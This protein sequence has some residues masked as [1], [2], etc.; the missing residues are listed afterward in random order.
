[1]RRI[2]LFLGVFSVGLVLFMALTGQL[3]R[4]I[5]EDRDPFDGSAWSDADDENVVVIQN[6]DAKNGRVRFKLRGVI[7][8]SEPLKIN[9]ARVRKPATLRDTVLEMP[10]DS[11]G[12]HPNLTEVPEKFTLRAAKVMY[13]P[14]ERLVTMSHGIVG[15][16]DLGSRVETESLQVTWTEGDERHI[17]L[18]G[19]RPVSIHYPAADLY[20][21]NGFSGELD[22]DVGLGTVV[23]RPPVVLAFDRSRSTAGFLGLHGSQPSGSDPAATERAFVVSE[24]PL[25]IER[26]AQRKIAYASFDG[27]VSVFSA[28]RETALHPRPAVA[29]EHFE[30]E[31]LRLEFDASMGLTSASAEG[32]EDPVAAV[33]LVGQRQDAVRIEGKGLTW[34]RDRMAVLSGDPGVRIIG[35]VG[36]ITARRA[37]FDPAT[38]ECSLEE[39]I[40]ARIHAADL[41]AGG[42][43]SDPRLTSWWRL[44][45]DEATL[46]FASRKEAPGGFRFIRARSI[47]PGGLVVAEDRE[48]GSRLIGSTLEYDSTSQ[49]LEMLGVESARPEYRE[50]PSRLAADGIRLHVSEEMLEFVGD[51][52]GRIHRMSLAPSS[53][54]ATS[55]NQKAYGYADVHGDRLELHW[56]RA[57]SRDRSQTLERVIG[58][59]G[60]SPLTIDL[61]TDRR[62]SLRG[63]QLEWSR[64][65]SIVR[66]EGEARQHLEI[67][68]ADGDPVLE[69]EADSLQYAIDTSTA[70]AVGNV[71][72]RTLRSFI[73]RRTLK[74]DQE[75]WVELRCH[76]IEAELTAP[77]L[78]EGAK[79]EGV[80]R[81]IATGSDPE[82]PVSIDDGVVSLE[83][84]KLDWRPVLGEVSIEGP[85]RQQLAYGDA[86]QR[87]RLEAQ[88]IVVRAPEIEGGKI[89]GTLEGEV[90]GQFEQ[91]AA[92]D[93]SS[94]RR[95]VPL[96]W[97]LATSRLSVAFS[98]ADTRDA[99]PLELESVAAEGG[100]EIRSRELDGSPLHFNGS[101]CTWD[102]GSQR[103]RVYSESGDTLQSRR[104]GPEDQR[105]EIVA[106]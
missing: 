104:R 82:H 105:D 77:D 85:G 89:R 47:A 59:G 19:S 22:N 95:P 3:S 29:P 38:R 67:R 55:G 93:P 86:E 72:G 21:E 35:P 62:V 27:S 20:G 4:F 94:R 16:S 69:L 5:Q 44:Q 56:T 49:V 88:R 65:D 50:G 75:R 17:A 58:V 6:A 24:G 98:V 13:R 11:A 9:D 39:S 61:Y 91:R 81:V 15:E 46:F 28:A 78:E 63:K 26:D 76:E 25:R 2:G 43:S 87:H 31:R 73:A 10:L 52:D 101:R 53:E 18:E 60:T 106:R 41:A 103:L 84:S 42:E 97:D 37:L 66:V 70:R 68:E 83:G 57:D 51:V 12:N 71:V 23:I 8:S 32:V 80:K 79:S 74:A 90:H 34:E 102:R 36:D 45:A 92:S 30:C 14:D 64:G 96:V 100:V 40:E 1:M 48:G 99:E 7:D 33:F 54:D